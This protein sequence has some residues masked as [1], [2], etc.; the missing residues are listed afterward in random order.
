V[1]FPT[2]TVYG[3]GA[4]A[5]EPSAVERIF[6]AKGRPATN[7]LI[8]HVAS[9]EQARSLA[10][11]WS[12]TADRLARRF[13]PGPLTL[14]LP[15]RGVVPEIVTAGGPT[16]ALRM[17]NHPVP[18]TLIELSGLPLAGP[19][20]NRSTRISPT[21]AQ[22]VL[23]ELAGRVDLILDAGPTTGG[24]ESTVLDLTSSPPRMLRPG[25]VTADQIEAALGRTLE[26]L[27][28]VARDA[29]AKSPGQM[30]R[31]YAPCI[32]LEV[33]TEGVETRLH[34]LTGKG[35]RVGWLAL[36]TRPVGL[37]STVIVVRMPGEAAGYSARLYA[38]LHE[39][40]DA[41]VER[42]VVTRPPTSREWGAIHDRLRRAAAG[43]A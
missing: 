35:A 14:V 10:A 24:L 2:E 25:L 6:S 7:P 5:L 28:Q 12:T 26:P 20:A 23:K 8:V 38:A 18:R 19:S 9:I 15:K 39:L 42:I 34:A 22:H 13:W 32:P 43:S 3:L 37:P 4:N 41:G 36:G 31:H 29:I 11:E 40:E 1:A 30:E 33:L 16:V 17:P 21:T 27:A